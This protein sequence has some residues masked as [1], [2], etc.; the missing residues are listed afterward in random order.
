MTPAGTEL[1]DDPFSED[2][3]AALNASLQV[4]PAWLVAIGGEI[5]WKDFANDT[6]FPSYFSRDGQEQEVTFD[7]YIY[8]LENRCILG[9][10]YAYRW[11]DVDGQQFALNSHHV[12][13][14]A[15][16]SLPGLLRFYASLSYDSEDYD[17]F[18]P[19][20]RRADDVLTGYAALSRPLGDVAWRAEVNVTYSTSESTLDFA[21]YNRT[22]YGVAVSWSP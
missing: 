13:G 17:E 12:A 15:T 19:E 5:S 20:P 14:S 16:A 4:V 18:T 1:G 7:S 6:E 8:L 10:S 9:L 11:N 2:V 21:D 3:S 22:V